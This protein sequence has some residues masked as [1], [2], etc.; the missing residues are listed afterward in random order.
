MKY[1]PQDDFEQNS[2]R[3]VG[4]LFNE[5]P[6]NQSI[7]EDYYK[8]IRTKSDFNGNQIKYESKGD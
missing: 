4:N 6:F 7:D 3:D 5:I 2:V 1:R 8:P